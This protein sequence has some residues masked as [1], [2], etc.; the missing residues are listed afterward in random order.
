MKGKTCIVIAH[1][2]ATIRRVDVIFVVKDSGVF[3]QGT[4]E[5]LLEAGGEYASFYQIQENSETKLERR[6]GWG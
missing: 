4:Q 6:F 2:L 3:E 1:H 5:E